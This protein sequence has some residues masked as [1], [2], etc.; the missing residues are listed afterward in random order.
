METVLIYRNLPFIL[1]DYID[2]GDL[3]NFYKCSFIIRMKNDD[4]PI[5]N[6]YNQSWILNTTLK[7]IVN[8]SRVYEYSNRKLNF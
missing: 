5:E 1:Y 3:Y 4:P 6:F 8:F 7:I 2:Q